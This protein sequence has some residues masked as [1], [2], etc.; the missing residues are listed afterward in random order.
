MGDILANAK[1]NIALYRM[2]IAYGVLFSINSLTTAIVLSFMNTTWDQLDHTSKFLLVVGILQNWTG[3]LLAFLS[4]AA[5]RLESGETPIPQV[6][7]T[8]VTKQALDNPGNIV[9]G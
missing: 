9:K 5:R 7:T 8:L 3:T 1:Q 2:A 4:K 6:D